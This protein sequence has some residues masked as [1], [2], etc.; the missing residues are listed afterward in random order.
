MPDPILENLDP[1]ASVE[2]LDLAP[3]DLLHVRVGIENMGDYLPPWIPSDEELAHVARE[4]QRVLSPD[5]RVLVTH[6]GIVAET[7]SEP[8][9]VV[10][11]AI[12]DDAGTD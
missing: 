11:E 4:F 1:I 2:K 6:A 9:L 3:G 8:K 10:I 5:V 7:Y 12:K